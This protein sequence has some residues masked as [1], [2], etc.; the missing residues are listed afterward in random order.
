M[1]LQNW[2]LSKKLAAVVAILLSP[3]LLLL[4]FI[5]SEKDSLIKFTRQELAGVAYISAMQQGFEAALNGVDASAASTAADAIEKAEAQDNGALSLSAKSRD[6]AN[7]LRGADMSDAATRL[8]DAISIAS[9]NSNITL[10]PD[11]DAYFIG[12]MLVNQA[13]AMMQKA[14]DLSTAAKSLQ[15]GKTEDALMAFAVARDGLS[16]A[17]TAFA[18]DYAK[19][20]K[21]NSDGAV[22]AA[23]N[24]DAEMAATRFAQL[25]KAAAAN[26]FGAVIKAAPE[27]GN[28]VTR[29]LPKLN[30]LMR[31]LL[32]ARISGFHATVLWRMLL[33][34]AFVA[35][36]LAASVVVIRSISGPIGELIRAIGLIQS[37]RYDIELPQAARK[38]EIGEMARALEVFKAAEIDKIRMMEAREAERLARERTDRQAAGTRAAEDVAR[39]EARRVAE[40]KAVEGEREM[41][42]ASIGAGLASLAARDLTYRVLDNLP[43][44][45]AKLQA[46][47]NDAAEAL[48]QAMRDVVEDSRAIGSMSGEIAEAADDIARRTEQQAATLEETAAAMEEL[49]VTVRNGADGANSAAD[50][51][52]RTRTEAE[53]SRSVVEEAV[54]AMDSIEKS[55]REIGKVLDMIDEIAFQTNLLALNASVE[56]ARAGEAGRGFA[57]VAS[58]VRALSQRSAE[59]AKEI[60]ALISS[61]SAQVAQGVNLVGRAGAA[62]GRIAGQVGQIDGLMSEIATAAREQ[63]GTLTE[64][65]KAV[66]S[67]DQT[68]QRNAE[69]V[70]KTS[71][72]TRALDSK[73]EDL[74]DLVGRFVI[75]EA[76]QRTSRESS[77]SSR[78][79]KSPERLKSSEAASA[80]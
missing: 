69:M 10:D 5:V 38:D 36:G 70:E 49:T 23:L 80:A 63:A 26:D 68:T 18:T 32:D 42:V 34:L 11:A 33:S 51:V 65:S 59:A 75:S 54:A 64:V 37:G 7:A 56:A 2:S 21:G 74:L 41:V 3:V 28:S 72:G 47:F 9:D 73:G 67:M 50:I 55:S 78:G 16:T 15:A 39:E 13:E 52:R 24:V 58:E 66:A 19:A 46:D 30:D 17:V 20:V 57:V 29:I 77:P 79:G 22:K 76:G 1:S 48:E 45:Y 8:T 27:A 71:L 14:S 53:Q 43:E 62:L 6:V 35:A 4:W 44:A 61:S 40:Q 31:R 12:D 60:N 25:Q